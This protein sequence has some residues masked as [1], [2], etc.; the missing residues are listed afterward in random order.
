M[1]IKEVTTIAS[2]AR[3]YTETLKTLP[4][5]LKSW[6]MTFWGEIERCDRKKMRLW[7]RRNKRKRS[8]KK[9]KK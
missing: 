9:K 1:P 4:E 8:K 2:E 6:V 3:E 5:L 7:R